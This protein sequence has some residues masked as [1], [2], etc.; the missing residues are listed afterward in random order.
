MIPGKSALKGDPWK[1]GL[2]DVHPPLT[3]KGQIWGLGHAHL[4]N[5][6]THVCV[7]SLLAGKHRL[8]LTGKRNFI[9]VSTGSAE[10]IKK[11]YLLLFH[12]HDVP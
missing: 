8:D 9:R 10:Q 1:V 12:G 5:C 7:L 4:R 11:A 3:L 2:F 6:C